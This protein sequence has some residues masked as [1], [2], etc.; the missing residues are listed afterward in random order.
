MRFFC[1][2]SGRKNFCIHSAIRSES[3]PDG[4]I[5]MNILPRGLAK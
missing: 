2:G 1:G 5:K 3:Q 4:N